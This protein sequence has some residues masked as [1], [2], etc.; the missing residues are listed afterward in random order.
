M[1]AQPSWLPRTE[2]RAGPEGPAKLIREAKKLGGGEGDRERPLP[3]RECTRSQPTHAG[4]TGHRSVAAPS[5]AMLHCSML[6]VHL[7]PAPLTHRR[8][9]RAGGSAACR[10]A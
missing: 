2:K 8:L 1:S 9:T 4:G 3:F 5:T 10:P 6:S 7:A